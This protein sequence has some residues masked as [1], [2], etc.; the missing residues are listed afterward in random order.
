MKNLKFA[1]EIYWSLQPFETVYDY[2]Y[3]HSG[4]LIKLK[5]NSIGQLITGYYY[6]TTAFA[7]LSMISYLINPE[8]VS[9]FGNI[10]SIRDWILRKRGL[11]G[12]NSC[13]KFLFNFRKIKL[14]IFLTSFYGTF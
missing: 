6:P 7:F 5:R 9:S 10:P 13:L 14:Y 11:Y 3:S 12:D 1:S 4:V 2:A 8:K